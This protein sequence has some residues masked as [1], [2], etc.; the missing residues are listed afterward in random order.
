MIRIKNVSKYFNKKKIINNINLEINDGEFIVL[1][2]AS[3]CGKTTTLK[4]INRLTSI[5]EGSIE[6]DGVNTKD[7]DLIKLRHNIGYVIQNV[8]LFPH[9]TILE[10]ITIILKLMKVSEQERYDRALELIEMVGLNESYFD[11]YPDALSGGQQQRVGVARALANNPNI[12]LM[13][14]PFSGLDPITKTQLQD[15]IV[16]LQKNL[17][18]TII[19]V[20]HDIDEALRIAD[21][22][23]IFENGEVLQFDTP[24]AILNQPANQYVLD[25]IGENKL[26]QNPSFIPITEVM[27]QAVTI[28]DNSSMLNA[29]KKMRSSKVDTLFVID[30]QNHYKGIIEMEQLLFVSPE[31][32]SLVSSYH[33]NTYQ[34]IQPTSMVDEAIALMIDTKQ[35][36]IPVVDDKQKLC[37]II[38]RSR[39]FT[40]IGTQFIHAESEVLEVE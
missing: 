9:M 19:F 4:M 18:K 34:T 20:T 37:G 32:N 22:I 25:F 23:C 33:A 8:G 29:A 36:I 17:K 30:E 31:P 35:K 24:Q 14:E 11:Y 1:L 15:E 5:T 6:I 12:I 39:L 27:S 13:D 2:G 21:R 38:T 26:W 10:N 40:S 3:G 7:M 16:D 28:R